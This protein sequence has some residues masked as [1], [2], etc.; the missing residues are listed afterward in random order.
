MGTWKSDFPGRMG[1]RPPQLRIATS[2]RSGSDEVMRTAIVCH[3]MQP[4]GLSS[5]SRS[6]E[7][8][9]CCAGCRGWGWTEQGP[10]PC[11]ASAGRWRRGLFWQAPGPRGP[12]RM[13]HLAGS[14]GQEMAPG[15][16]S[17]LGWGGRVHR[18]PVCLMFQPGLALLCDGHV[19][20]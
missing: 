7:I 3:R 4:R 19:P 18:G 17:Q 1:T 12:G 8:A 5:F 13:E 16:V 10:C 14:E 6:A 20:G 11:A 9:R 15:C 2:V